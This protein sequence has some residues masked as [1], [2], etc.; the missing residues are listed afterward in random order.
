VI[1]VGDA[2]RVAGSPMLAFRGYSSM[3]NRAAAF[4][5]ET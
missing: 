2:A 3:E 4:R 5:C 1:K